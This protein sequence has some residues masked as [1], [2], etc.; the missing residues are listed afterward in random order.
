[1]AQGAWPGLWL[2]GGGL[3]A[4]SFA[5]H[6]GRHPQQASRCRSGAWWPLVAPL[7]KHLQTFLS[8]CVFLQVEVEPANLSDEATQA[9]AD[10]ELRHVLVASFDASSWTRAHYTKI[11]S[12]CIGFGG[13]LYSGLFPIGICKGGDGEEDIRQSFASSPAPGVA[14]ICQQLAQLKPFLADLPAKFFNR[15]KLFINPRLAVVVDQ[16]AMA[17]VMGKGGLVHNA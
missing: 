6:N 13:K 14:G 9:G 5:H 1:V 16:P 2:R 11:T 4:S 17:A 7:P 10:C 3:E 15:T 12:F 8:T